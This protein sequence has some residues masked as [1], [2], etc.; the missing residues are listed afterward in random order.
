[1]KNIQTYCDKIEDIIASRMSSKG[2][3]KKSKGLLAPSKDATTKTTTKDRGQFEMIAD[4]VQ[5]IREAKEEI[6]NARK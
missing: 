2:A 4:I 3:T 1:M 6:L 5:G